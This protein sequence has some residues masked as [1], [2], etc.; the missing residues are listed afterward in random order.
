MILWLL[1]IIT[2]VL[3]QGYLIENK[4][5]KPNYI[6][7]FITRGI[8]SIVHG[9]IIDTQNIYPDYIALLLFQMTSFW[10]FFDLGLNWYR[11]KPIFYSGRTSG[12]IDRY[13]G[14][15]R[16]YVP[17]KLV[18]LIV[19]ITSYIVGLQYWNF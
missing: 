1:Y 3:L 5:W 8:A 16:L 2:E 18:A 17:L 11:K 6:Q 9:A 14:T 4:S 15:T 12:W 10:I 19:M 7:L 13:L